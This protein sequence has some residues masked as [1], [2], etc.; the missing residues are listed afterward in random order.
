MALAAH[1]PCD[2]APIRRTVSAVEIAFEAPLALGLRQALS[3]ANRARVGDLAPKLFLAA[4]TEPGLGHA[5]HQ[6]VMIDASLFE[7]AIESVDGGEL[8]A[9][10]GRRQHQKHLAKPLD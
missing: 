7:R 9:I 6:R 10:D 4:V 2:L 8:V 3:L 5:R 1:E